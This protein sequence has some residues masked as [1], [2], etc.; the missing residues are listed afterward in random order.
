MKHL[1][2][3]L[4]LTGLTSS[5]LSSCIDPAIANLI[6]RANQT[7][8]QK[9]T[10]TP[11]P[12]SSPTSSSSGSVSLDLNID[13]AAAAS[14]EGMKASNCS[15]EGS[16]KSATGPATSVD[17]KNESSADISIYWLNAQGKRVLYK[18]LSAGSDYTQSTY[19][20]HPWLI[21]NAQGN[22]IGIYTPESSSKS[23]LKITSQGSS[24]SGSTSSSANVS[25]GSSVTGTPTPERVQQ[26]ITCLKAKGDTTN[27]TA[28]T[29]LLNLYTS[30]SKVVGA[31]VAAKGYLSGTTSVI[32]KTGC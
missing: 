12:S 4:I 2:S 19:V 1:F 25:A 28:L 8:E 31:D 23:N 29:G 11:S 27:A 18:K 13:A 26:A 14:L 16:I 5:L 17:F 15:Q 32:N 22:C 24:A 10:A 9:K 30:M 3:A 20:T 7:L 21:T 6:N